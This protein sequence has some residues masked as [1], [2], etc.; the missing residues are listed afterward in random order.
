MASYKSTRVRP[1]RRRWVGAVLLIVSAPWIPSAVFRASAAEQPKQNPHEKG[2]TYYALEARTGRL[3]T[4]FANGHETV[5]ERDMSGVVRT[6]LRDRSGNELARRRQQVPFTMDAASR[7]TAAKNDSDV[8]EVVAEWPDGLTATLTRQTYARRNLGQGR[9]AQGPALVSDVTLYGVPVGKGV[10]F[11]NDQVYAY[12]FASGLGGGVIA[13][14]H[15][16]QHYGNW[17]FTPDTTWVNLQTLALYAAAAQAKTQGVVAKNCSSPSGPAPSRLAQF[18]FPTVQAN[19]PGCDGMHWLD[20][21]IL[22][23]C[24]DQHDRCYGRSGCSSMSWWRPWSGWSCDYCNMEV[25][26]CFVNGGDPGC[27]LMRLAC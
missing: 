12:S 6:V 4:R 9:F 26:A 19:E 16:K 20:G 1:I 27:G 13:P 14:E 7:Q 3:T 21:T 2:T 8:A 23:A 22:R 18:F 25:I 5:S 24:C 10:W 15:L 11:I 17:G